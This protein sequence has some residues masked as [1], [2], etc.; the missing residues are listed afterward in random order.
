MG[1]T[2]AKMLEYLFVTALGCVGAYY[3]ATS[4]GNAVSA[5]FQHTADL[6]DNASSH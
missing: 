3:V 5:S 2:M 6:I 4:V 1:R